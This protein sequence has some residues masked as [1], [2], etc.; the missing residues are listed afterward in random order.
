VKERSMKQAV[1]GTTTTAP[2]SPG[3]VAEG[4]VLYVSGQVPVRN[5]E[6]VSGDIREQTRQVLEN[7]GTVLQAG[8]ATF[9]DVVRCGVYLVD[10][11]DFADMNAVYETFFPEP[12]PARTTIGAP[13]VGGIAV[14]IDCIA[15]VDR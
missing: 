15:V 14:E 8:G 11:D 6:R 5:G 1:Q 7:V 4:R 9:A 10:I 3:I 13:L 2:L 12:R